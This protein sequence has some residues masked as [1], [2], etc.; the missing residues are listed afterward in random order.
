MRGVEDEDLDHILI[1]G[2]CFIERLSRRERL[3]YNKVS[4]VS[5]TKKVAPD[6]TRLRKLVYALTPGCDSELY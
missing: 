5:R 4:R 2:P 3:S 6:S 1:G